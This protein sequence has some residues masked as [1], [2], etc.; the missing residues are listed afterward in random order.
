[1]VA[2]RHDPAHALLVSDRPILIKTCRADDGWLV[3]S[4]LGH[5]FVF[6]AIRG[7]VAL[8]LGFWVVGR[9]VVTVA[10]DDVVLD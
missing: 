8:D 3:D 1:M 2:C 7:H 6:T 4:P 5:D 10:L 9:V